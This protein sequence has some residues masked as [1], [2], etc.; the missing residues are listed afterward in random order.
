MAAARWPP[1]YRQTL[2]GME[3]WQGW[4]DLGSKNQQGMALGKVPTSGTGRPKTR[5][6]QLHRRTGTFRPPGLEAAYKYLGQE[7]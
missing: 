6:V 1:L 7:G 2:L 4:A 3:L 5:E